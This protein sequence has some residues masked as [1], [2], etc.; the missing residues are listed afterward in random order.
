[1]TLFAIFSASLAS[2]AV[3]FTEAALWAAAGL[4]LIPTTVLLAECLAA[5]WPAR[6][7]AVAVRPRLAV[8]VP[9][10]NEVLGIQPVLNQILTELKSDDRLVVIADNCTDETA[11]A[12]RATG[13]TVIERHDSERRG[14]GYALDYGLQF[15]AEA[16]PPD[17]VVV[18]DADCLVQPGT[19]EQ[20][21][22]T[23]AATGRPVQATYLMERPAQPQPKDAV[24]ALAFLV[25]NWVRPQGLDRLGFPGI[26]TGTGMAFPWS[27]IRSVSMASGNIVEDMQ[28]SMDLAI[29]GYPTLFCPDSRVIGLL[30]QQA[31]AAKSQRT[32]WEHGHLQTML[33]EVPRLFQE[34]LRQK[35]LDLLVIALDLSVPPL[36]LL[37]ILWGAVLLLA[38]AVGL[39]TNLWL[40]MALLSV[41]GAMI[42]T[43]ILSAWLKFGRADLPALTLLA[44]PFYLLW[45]IPLYLAYAV[46]PQTKWVRTERDA[47][48]K[49]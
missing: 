43:A 9:A 49:S 28:L 7:Q 16:N 27:V 25:K 31:Q 20:I 24:S 29:A 45:K 2:F 32:R 42:L 14:K 47:V 48:S 35:R 39:L 33:R 5:L 15:L 46:R 44:V 13:A 18:V 34:A 23:A 3:L 8:L 12:A 37:V 41:E 22:A 6:R 11:I 19:L 30:P 10:H 4:L 21:A 40:P 36:S 17:V 38:V 1:M 26:L